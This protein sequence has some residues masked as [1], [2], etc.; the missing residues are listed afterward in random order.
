MVLTQVERNKAG[1][2]PNKLFSQARESIIYVRSVV[3][4]YLN[5]HSV[6]TYEDEQEDSSSEFLW[7]KILDEDI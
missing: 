4:K 1:N 5:V 3:G 6:S 7:M 2:N